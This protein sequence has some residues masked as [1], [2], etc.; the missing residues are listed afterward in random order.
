MRAQERNLDPRRTR[1]SS[2]DRE[3]GPGDRHTA[4]RGRR[5]DGAIGAGLAGRRLQVALARAIV[6]VKGER[7]GAVAG[8]ASQGRTAAPSIE[9]SIEDPSISKTMY[10]H[11][12]SKLKDQLVP[13]PV[14]TNK[15]EV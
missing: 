1:H 6:D 4:L 11:Q 3:N 8:A 15:Q 2:S 9:T 7:H 5:G 14:T 12:P 13:L 10:T